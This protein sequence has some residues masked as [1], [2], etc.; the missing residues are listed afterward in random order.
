MLI[1]IFY[2]GTISSF[3]RLCLSISNSL[4]EVFKKRKEIRITLFL[5]LLSKDMI[6]KIK[7]FIILE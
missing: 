6:Q 3:G 7:K 2:Y 5:I 4:C 1:Y